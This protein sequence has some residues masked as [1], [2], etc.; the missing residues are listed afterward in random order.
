MELFSFDLNEET[1]Y[2]PHENMEITAEEKLLKLIS[3]FVIVNC[4]GDKF[5]R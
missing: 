3:C 4:N 2:E 5:V 1:I